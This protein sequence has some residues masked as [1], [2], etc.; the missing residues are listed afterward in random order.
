MAAEMM[1]EM[2]KIK[3]KFGYYLKG[4]YLCGDFCKIELS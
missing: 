1:D 4:V 3:E 2:K